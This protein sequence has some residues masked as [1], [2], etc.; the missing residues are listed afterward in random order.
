MEGS[1]LWGGFNKKRR[2]PPLPPPLSFFF[3]LTEPSSLPPTPPFSHSLATPVCSLCVN[4]IVAVE[5]GFQHYGELAQKM[6]KKGKQHQQTTK[7]NQRAEILLS[8]P[9]LSFWKTNF[10]AGSSLTSPPPPTLFP[11]SPRRSGSRKLPSGEKRAFPF[12]ASFLYNVRFS[13]ISLTPPPCTACGTRGHVANVPRVREP[14]IWQPAAQG[15]TP[16][17]PDTHNHTSTGQHGSCI[18]PVSFDGFL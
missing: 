8:F 4:A 9:P 13:T 1:Q 14:H 7:P 15:P 6:Q 16:T 10:D 5:D 3:C 18:Q 12:C 11:S 2:E 17:T